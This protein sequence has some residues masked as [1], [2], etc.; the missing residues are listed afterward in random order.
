VKI[1]MIILFKE[2]HVRYCLKIARHNNK[3]YSSV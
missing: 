3:K 2:T 1:A